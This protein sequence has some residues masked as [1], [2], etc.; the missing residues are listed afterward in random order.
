[1]KTKRL[2]MFFAAAAALGLLLAPSAMAVGTLAGTVI[3]NQAFADYNDANG[4][5][6]T[7]VYSNTVT[8]TVS[9]VAGISVTPETNTREGIAGG[10]VYYGVTICNTGNGPDTADLALSG[11]AWDAVIYFDDNGDGVWDPLVETTVVDNTGVLAADACYRVIVVTDVPPEAGNGDSD[12]IVLTGTSRFNPAVADTGTYTTTAE[13]A[14]FEIAKYVVDTPANPVPGDIITY[15][16]TGTNSGSAPTEDIRAE[17][18]IPAGTSYVAGSMRVGLITDGYTDATS[19]TDDDDGDEIGDIGGYFDGT[20]VVYTKGSFG[21][22]DT[23]SFFFQVEVNTGVLENTVISNQLTAYYK[24]EGLPTEYTSSSNLTGT[25]VGFTAAIDL[26][27]DRIGTGNPG[28]QIVYAFTATNNGNAADRI[29]ITRS[30]TDGWTWV[31]WA[32]V[33]GNGIPGTNGDYIL[34]DTNADSIIDTGVLTPNGGSIQLLA[35]TTIPAGLPDGQVDITTVTGTSARDNAATDSITLTTTVTAPV[36]SITKSVSPEGPQP[37]GTVLTYTVT[38]TNSGTG[39]AASVIVTDL[40]PAY[41]TYQ[42]GSLET[43]STPGTLTSRTDEQDGDGASYVEGSNTV[44][45]DPSTLGPT[46][47]RILQFQVVID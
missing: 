30:S 9:Q 38:V 17:D 5:P 39:N 37:P 20:K 16:V 43:G 24:H 12:A 36:L 6:R 44:I 21:A 28:D 26:D 34:A 29:N 45:T 3:E 18:V 46:G 14:L 47:A 27:P 35:V 4:N 7:R 13:S 11:N 22:G 23:G 15:K 32:D 40:V 10:R 42:A 8:T 1:M 19:I 33:D 2:L 31:I 41:T 25:S